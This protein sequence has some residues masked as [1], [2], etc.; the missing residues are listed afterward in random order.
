MGRARCAGRERRSDWAEMVRP[1]T[2][3]ADVLIV[4]AGPAGMVLAALLDRLG[5]SVRVVEKHRTRLELPKAHLINPV[6][7]DICA[8]AGFDVEQ[9]VAAA[10]PREFDRVGRLRQT[11]FGPDLAEVPFELQPAEWAPRP[12]INVDQPRFEALLEEEL[13]R[14]PGVELCYGTWLGCADRGS[15]VLS[16]VVVDGER[17]IFTSSYVVGAD[18]ARSAVRDH[19]GIA[20]QK[21]APSTDSVTIQ[22][23]AD[24]AAE[25]LKHPASMVAVSARS[26]T[27]MIQFHGWA[28]PLTYN[29]L[30]EKAPANVHEAIAVVHEV[31]GR[32]DVPVKISAISTWQAEVKLADNFRAG[33]VLLIG[34]AAHR[35]PPTGGLGLNTA[36]GDSANLAWKIAAVLRDWAGDALLDTYEAERRGVALVNCQRSD[37]NRGGPAASSLEGLSSRLHNALNN[38]GLQLGYGYASGQEITVPS[39]YEPSADV[40]R[41]LPHV[42]VATAARSVPI[43]DLVDRGFLTVLTNGDVSQWNQAVTATTFPVVL[44]DIRGAVAQGWLDIFGLTC[45]GSALVVRPD[46]HILFRCNGV[47]DWPAAERTSAAHLRQGIGFRSKPRLEEHIR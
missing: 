34:D 30:D 31:I 11:F 37:A 8:Q 35:M 26:E 45:I 38:P 13:R 2:Q 12:R 27:G 9:I 16:T 24:L 39:E 41:R 32:D 36:V 44:V 29:S 47:C 21:L 18:G 15:D 25:F 28:E 19:A 40:G 33:R 20:M 7:L 1:D 43:I 22:F 4:G 14:R 10:L 23:V 5:V 3:S 42:S 6:T 17:R 46:G